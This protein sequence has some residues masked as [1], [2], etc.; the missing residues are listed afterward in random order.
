MNAS[1]QTITPTSE[2]AAGELDAMQLGAL[3][4]M[5]E[6][7]SDDESDD[8]LGPGMELNGVSLSKP[9]HLAPGC[10]GFFLGGGVSNGIKTTG[11]VERVTLLPRCGGLIRVSV[12]CGDVLKTLWIKEYEQAEEV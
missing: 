11:I 1:T 8:E 10:A 3:G 7:E 5:Q 6:D 2:P 12:R 9:L 4:Q